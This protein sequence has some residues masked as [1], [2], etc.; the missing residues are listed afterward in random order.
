[1]SGTLALSVMTPVGKA[2]EADTPEVVLPGYEGELC[3]LPMH[4]TFLA[5]LVPGKM[6]W[7]EAGQRQTAVIKGGLV[8]VESDRVIVLTE[9]AVGAGER[10]AEWCATA[11]DDARRH[12][13]A[14]LEQGQPT[15]SLREDLAFLEALQSA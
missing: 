8:E 5:L 11:V 9:E 10:S 1:M 13:D 15:G 3:I 2:F 12:L 14:A 7:I 4:T 6:S